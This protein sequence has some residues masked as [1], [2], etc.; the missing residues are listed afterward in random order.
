MLRAPRNGQAG[1]VNEQW[2]YT[3]EE[4]FFGNDHFVLAARINEQVVEQRINVNIKP[5]NDV[6]RLVNPKAALQLEAGRVSRMTFTAVDV[7]KSDLTFALKAPAQLGTAVMERNQLVYTAADK[8]GQETLTLVVSDGSDQLEHNIAVTVQEAE[9]ESLPL[10]LVSTRLNVAEDKSLQ[11]QLQSKGGQEDKVRFRLLTQ[12][13]NAESVNL[14]AQ[15]RLT[16]QPKANFNGEEQL[17]IEV[18]DGDQTISEWL[19]ITVESVN[20]A[21]QLDTAQLQLNMQ[22]GEQVARTLKAEDV[23]GDALTLSQGEAPQQGTVTLQPNSM[24]WQYQANQNATGDDRFS[25]RVSDGTV[26]A[27][28]VVTVSIEAAT[29]P[30]IQ[31]QPLSVTED[32]ELSVQLQPQGNN[33]PSL[34]YEL[35]T[36]ASHGEATLTESGQL[37]YQPE[38]NFNGTETLSIKVGSSGYSDKT[39]NVVVQVAPVNDAPV[40]NMPTQ[41]YEVSADQAIRIS[42]V[43]TDV[44]K[45]QLQYAVLSGGNLG[46][47]QFEENVL[48]YRAAKD[49]SGED[50]LRVQV[51]DGA[52]TDQVDLTVNV[53]E[54][55]QLPNGEDPLYAQQWHLKNTGQSAYARN[56][57]TAGHDIN[58]EPVHRLGLLGENIRVAVVDTGLEINHPDLR[59]NV[60]ANRSYDFVGGDTDPTPAMNP[61]NPAGGDHGTSVAGLIAARGFNGIGGRGVAPYAE[62]MGFNF[63]ENQTNDNWFR[64]HGGAPSAA[65]PG[66]P[67]SDDALVINMSYGSDYIQPGRGPNRWL[68]DFRRD[69]TTNNNG[70]RGVAY[71]KSAGNSFKG[72]EVGGYQFAGRTA[73]WITGVNPDLADHIANTTGDNSTF[74]YTVVSALAAD[75]DTPL[76]SYSSVGS[77]IWVSAP[78]GEYGG[79]HPA[80]IT[81]DLTSCEHG[82]SR[83]G[84][85]HNFDNGSI[86]ENSDCDYTST[87]NGTSSAAPVVSGV[88]ALIF[89]ANDLLT[90][91]DVRHIM[92]MTARKIDDDFAPRTV[93]VGNGSLFT[94]EPGWVQNAAGHWFH[95]WYGF[96]MVDTHAAVNLARAS[97]YELLPPYQETG[98]VDSADIN[99]APIPDGST[100]GA[101]KTVVINDDITVEAI[102]VKFS[103]IHGRD[104]DLAV[105]VRSPSGTEAMVLQPRSMLVAD[106]SENVSADFDDTVLL[107]NAFYGESAQ[108]TWTVK[109]VDTNSG[110]F[111]FQ[112]TLLDAT[113]T[114]TDDVVIRTANPASQ[115]SFTEAAINIYGH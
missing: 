61:L 62:L 30:D 8:A 19:S 96:G 12:G 33:V 76:S 86:D 58:V 82:S 35:L 59:D 111:R 81:T 2:Q 91:R 18:S 22:A 80:M 83:S 90:W 97:D 105:M 20:D 79:R 31:F 51:S 115:G 114:R 74:Y 41:S 16:Y 13:A 64:S 1:I 75:A 101:E 55:N 110:E 37:T 32:A 54:L 78:G 113:G 69:K 95:N 39:L 40:F 10:E 52:L 21:P 67:R 43:T 38:A 5:V 26:T 63:L 45:D 24:D 49:S 3:P 99:P 107:S 84:L 104:A 34:S 102:Q 56:A 71:I 77:S 4:N 109:L 23:D 42:L 112:A 9:V 28:M 15:G 93:D 7:E 57:G 44:D 6:P 72:I 11:A 46:Q 60:V 108:G 73:N 47:V 14:T 94:A 53:Q 48:V 17:H 87:F 85:W 100:V 89:E 98:F 103:A 88:A 68:E 27:D 36:N 25:L 50:R 106:Q 66:G 70:G 29:L 92:A 65:S